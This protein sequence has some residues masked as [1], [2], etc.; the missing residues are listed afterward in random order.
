MYCDLTTGGDGLIERAITLSTDFDFTYSDV[1]V[2]I[3]GWFG[4]RVGATPH[5]ADSLGSGLATGPNP[6][7]SAVYLVGEWLV[8]NVLLSAYVAVRND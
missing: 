1:A 6:F 3:F 5:D 2:T 8:D 4:L 7:L